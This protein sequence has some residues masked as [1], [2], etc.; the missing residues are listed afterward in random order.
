MLDIETLPLL[1]TVVGSYPTGGLPPR[2]AILR[3]VED[4][5]AAG[6]ELISDGQVRTDMISLFA[7]RIPGFELAAD[8]V[9]EVVDALDQAS[10]PITL[11]DYQLARQFATGHAEVK[12]IVTG[13]ITL[14]LAS[15]IVPGAPYRGPDDPALI[16]RLS[17]ILAHEVVALCAAGAQVV[18][19]DEPMLPAALG[20]R[21]S[22]ELAADA[23]RELAAT[24][25]ISV[26]HVCGDLRAV[27]SEVLLFSFGVLDIE[28]TR[29]ANLAAFDADQIEFSETRLSV[30]VVDTQDAALESPAQLRAR[31]RNAARAVAPERLWISPDCGLRNLP[32]DMAR[33]KL[34][35]MVAA[36]QDVRAEL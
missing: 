1:T 13:P 16:L 8:G 18:Q 7:S 33:E 5:L 15:R 27:A 21:V 19:V 3:A 34:T 26:L 30:G 12:G 24:P 17:E 32:P 10:E 20:E 22:G 14:A 28:N 36:V 6:V 2:R 35:R 4:Q 25:A 31:V 11:A 9:W 29:I 23:L